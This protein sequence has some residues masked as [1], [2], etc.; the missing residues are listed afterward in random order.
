MS[1]KCPHCGEHLEVLKS[2]D[3]T[4]A[5]P[6]GD[7][8]ADLAGGIIQATA[9]AIDAKIEKVSGKEAAISSLEAL[10]NLANGS[11][12]SGDSG[13]A[14]G[15]GG[16]MVD[17]LKSRT[18]QDSRPGYDPADLA[19]ADPESVDKDAAAKTMQSLIHGALNKGA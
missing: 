11:L 13:L 5:Q 16:A 12:G 9:A 15:W 18:E 2:E 8:T 4:K 3:I 10:N 19:K 14:A 1:F 6:V 7:P 17:S